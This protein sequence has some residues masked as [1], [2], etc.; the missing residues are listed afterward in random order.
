M[1]DK[2]RQGWV[3]KG[4]G[5]NSCI[6]KTLTPK[7][8]HQNP[9]APGLNFVLGKVYLRRSDSEPKQVCPGGEAR[10]SRHFQ[11]EEQGCHGTE[12][13][14]KSWT[15]NQLYEQKIYNGRKAASNRALQER[16]GEPN[17]KQGNRL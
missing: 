10:L 5:A 4:S 16:P 11:K 8:L 12:L 2:L 7:A 3:S 6:V 17:D 1:F 15:Q 13:S 14:P 9:L